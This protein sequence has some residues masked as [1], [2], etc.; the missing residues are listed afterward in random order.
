MLDDNNGWH[1]NLKGGDVI[2]WLEVTNSIYP[3]FVFRDPARRDEL[4]PVFVWWH[5]LSH[6]LIRSIST[7]AGYPSAS[8]RERVYLERSASRVRG[9]ILLYAAQPG[10]EGTM[11]GLVALVPHFQQ[12]FQRTFDMLDRCSGDP[13]CIE[14]QFQSGHYSGAACYGCL[15]LS[16]TSCEH[17]NMWLD[18]RILRGNLP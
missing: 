18:R 14:N 15:F 16:E 8:I 2:R 13:L 1:F 3:D 10:S 9:G 7:E 4:H 17:R 12:I 6:L 11:G 5:T